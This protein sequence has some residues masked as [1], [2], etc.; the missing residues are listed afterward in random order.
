MDTLT[1]RE[2]DILQ[3]LATGRTMKEI[4]SMLFI[5]HHTVLSHRKN[6]NE[7]LKIRSA[8]QLGVLIERHGLLTKE[9]NFVPLPL[10]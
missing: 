6:L 5:S 9:Q 8:V 1:K 10:S 2:K 7:K 3:L 4:S